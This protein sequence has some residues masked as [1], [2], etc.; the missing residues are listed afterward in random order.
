VLVPNVDLPAL[1]SPQF[2]PGPPADEAQILSAQLNRILSQSVY[3]PTGPAP[4]SL[5]ADDPTRCPFTSPSVLPLS[6]LG[7]ESGRA[8]W[9]LY[10]DVVCINYDGNPLD[11]CLVAVMAALRNSA[12]YPPRSPDAGLAEG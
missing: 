5:T 7:I 4:R 6:S 9:V 2:K 12:C 10:I 11:A 3:S 8:A 1:C